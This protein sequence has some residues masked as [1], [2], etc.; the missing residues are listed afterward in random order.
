MK[1]KAEP[2]VPTEVPP[3]DP[4]L[5]T[6]PPAEP[7]STEPPKS[8]PASGGGSQETP[9]NGVGKAKGGEGFR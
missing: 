6:I 7:P 1:A 4:S 3:D 8:D 9:P 5:I 2:E